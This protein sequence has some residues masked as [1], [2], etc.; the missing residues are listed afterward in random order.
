MAEN[1]DNTTLTPS[2]WSLTPEEWES[3][4]QNLGIVAASKLAGACIQYF[5]YGEEPDIKLTRQ[6][7][8]LFNAERRRLDRRR[9]SALNGARSCTRSASGDVDNHGTA[10]V[11][12][13]KR[14]K[15][16]TKKATE[17]AGK[18][19]SRESRVQNAPRPAQMQPA[20][21][22][23]AHI[24][25]HQHP[26]PQT[27]TASTGADGGGGGDG[28]VTPQEFAELAASLGFTSPTAYGGMLRA[29]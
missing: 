7:S 12:N 4:V 9:A 18:E 3:W 1:T 22:P 2:F 11:E 20:S 13:K 26:S 21:P 29:V 17:K 5:F 6:A 24:S 28:R 27:P 16:P 23:P 15:K 10:D 19:T 8:A 25:L 14:A